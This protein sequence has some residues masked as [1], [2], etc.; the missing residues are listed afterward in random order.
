[1]I[2]EINTPDGPKKMLLGYHSVKALAE[3]QKRDDD[4]ITMIE[5]VALSGFNTHE[6]REGTD[7]TT[8]DQM[9]EWFDDFD[10]FLDVKETVEEFSVNF[11]QK[12]SQREKAKQKSKK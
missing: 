3:S 1:M 6:K 9:L 2:K 8:K 11:T 10:V 4:E 12:V 5:S 7:L